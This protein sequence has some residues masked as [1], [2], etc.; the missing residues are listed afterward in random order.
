MANKVDKPN[1][2]KEVVHI[3]RNLTPP[4]RFLKLISNSEGSGSWYDVG[5]A[6][7][8]EKASQCLRER[9]PDVQPFVNSLKAIHQDSSMEKKKR[10]LKVSTNT[11]EVSASSVVSPNKM[12]ATSTCVDDNALNSSIINLKI[13]NHDVSQG[14]QQKGISAQSTFTCSCTIDKYMQP[15]TSPAQSSG[16][17]IQE[18]MINLIVPTQLSLISEIQDNLTSQN[19]STKGAVSTQVPRANGASY[20]ALFSN[21]YFNCFYGLNTAF[22]A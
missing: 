20:P 1:V 15:V 8:R 6:K 5:D 10:G 12:P 7:A 9:T 3:W 14:V 22:G 21:P 17:N 11:N 18:P 4:G 2:A 16:H 19:N 13:P